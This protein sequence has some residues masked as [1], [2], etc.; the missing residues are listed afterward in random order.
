MFFSDAE[1]NFSE[2]KELFLSV[3][4]VIFGRWGYSPRYAH[5]SQ[6]GYT[7]TKRVSSA[8]H[9]SRLESVWR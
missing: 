5:S 9:I 8:F 3:S 1:D 7:E 4:G 2:G 6:V